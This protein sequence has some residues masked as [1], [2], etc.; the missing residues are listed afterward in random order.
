[1]KAE[2][3]ITKVFQE[4]KVLRWALSFVIFGISS[5]KYFSLSLAGLLIIIIIIIIIIM[6]YAAAAVIS[7]DRKEWAIIFNDFAI[8]TRNDFVCGI[9]LFE[10]LIMQKMLQAMFVLRSLSIISLN[11]YYLFRHENFLLLYVYWDIGI[12][13]FML[14]MDIFVCHNFQGKWVFKKVLKCENYFIFN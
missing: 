1:M 12:F 9:F 5:I 14:I 2:R 7:I 10:S 6:P 11:D 4:C 13:Y 8:F 3:D